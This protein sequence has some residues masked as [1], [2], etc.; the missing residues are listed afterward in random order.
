M[1]SYSYTQLGK[2]LKGNQIPPAPFVKVKLTST[3]IGCNEAIDCSA[4]LDTGSALTLFPRNWIVPHL[5]KAPVG[6][7]ENAYGVG[8]GKVI[9]IPY[10]V[11]IR[12]GD[13]YYAKVKVWGYVDNELEIKDEIPIIGRDFMR[14]LRIEFDGINSIA[15]IHPK[16]C[17]LKTCPLKNN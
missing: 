17:P 9:A 4:L 7:A 12:I 3:E 13:Q 15:N 1:S 10:I 5:C 16:L 11:N 14:R 8:G 6:E 2:T